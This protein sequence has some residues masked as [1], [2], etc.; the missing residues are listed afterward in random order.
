M[1]GWRVE[2]L[3]FS[4]DRVGHRAATNTWEV[5]RFS[6]DTAMQFRR[7]VIMCA[8]EDRIESMLLKFTQY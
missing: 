2:G 4:T 7:L 6:R 8:E 5:K 1:K 3:G